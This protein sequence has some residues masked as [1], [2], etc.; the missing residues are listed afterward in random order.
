MRNLAVHMFMSNNTL[1]IF[2]AQRQTTNSKAFEPFIQKKKGK[3]G[4][5]KTKFSFNPMCTGQCVLYCIDLIKYHT[6]TLLLFVS[7]WLS[8]DTEQL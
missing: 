2:P 1:E 5:A 8:R 4:P 6:T 7:P 3:F